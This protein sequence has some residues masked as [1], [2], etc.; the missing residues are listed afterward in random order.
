M[1]LWWKVQALVHKGDRVNSV[2]LCI[3]AWTQV[4]FL[5]SDYPIEVVKGHFWEKQTAVLWPVKCSVTPRLH[6][7]RRS[8]YFCAKPMGNLAQAAGAHLQVF[9]PY[10]GNEMQPCCWNYPFLVLPRQRN[11]G[12]SQFWCTTFE[13]QRKI[14]PQMYSNTTEV[15]NICN[16]NRQLLPEICT[17]P[18]FGHCCP[19]SLQKW[20][21]RPL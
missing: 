10:W 7:A 17:S 4:L 14:N 20:T 3:R 6:F 16:L 19:L 2:K 15:C 8:G 1:L 11:W 21:W 13:V 18:S 5:K 9:A 12:R